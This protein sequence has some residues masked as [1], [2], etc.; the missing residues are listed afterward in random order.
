[1]V[2]LDPT[3]LVLAEESFTPEDYI[4]VS[5]AL[6]ARREE[7]HR[8]EVEEP[9][10][11]EGEFQQEVDFE[12]KRL[13]DSMIN[14]LVKQEQTEKKEEREAAKREKEE[15][16]VAREVGF[17]MNDIFKGVEKILKKDGYQG[18]YDFDKKPPKPKKE[19]EAAA[20]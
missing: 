19:S 6:A 8:K 15:R 18:I 1:M 2:L 20:P 7:R 17:A 9:E 4:A 5:D 12:A 14:E 10:V 3:N 11:A 16:K 13:V